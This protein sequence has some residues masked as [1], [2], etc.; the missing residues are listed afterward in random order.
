MKYLIFRCAELHMQH[1]ASDDPFETGSSRPLDFGHWSAHKLETLS[2][3]EVLHGEAVAMGMALDTVYSNLSGRLSEHET[4]RIIK[5]LRRFGF[6]LI[7][8]LMEPSG[9]KNSILSGLDEFREHLGGK[10]TI[11]LLEGIGAGTEVHEMDRQ[12]LTSS[13]EKLKAF[14]TDGGTGK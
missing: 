7:H 8:P 11:M 10:L 9:D 3:F 4:G 6:D 2:G 5:L 12:I 1:I 13:V 14:Q